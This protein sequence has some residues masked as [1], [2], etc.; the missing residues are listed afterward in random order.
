MLANHGTD[1]KMEVTSACPLGIHLT[2]KANSARLI[3]IFSSSCHGRN[4]TASTASGKH[5]G[6]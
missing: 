3:H 4:R 2:L 1:T 6:M 5:G